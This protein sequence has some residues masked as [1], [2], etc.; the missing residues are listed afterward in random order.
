MRIENVSHVDMDKGKFA[1][2]S[3]SHGKHQKWRQI[4]KNKTFSHQAAKM[5]EE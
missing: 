1:I 2:R 4:K 5:G 3:S